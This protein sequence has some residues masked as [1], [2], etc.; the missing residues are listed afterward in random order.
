M[1][2]KRRSNVINHIN[3]SQNNHMLELYFMKNCFDETSNQQTGKR[4]ELIYDIAYPFDP[5]EFENEFYRDMFLLNEI[6]YLKQ[7]SK[8]LSASEHTFEELLENSDSN[9]QEKINLETKSIEQRNTRYG[10]KTELISIDDLIEFKSIQ[11][12]N[13]E[14]NDLIKILISYGYKFT[15]NYKYLVQDSNYE[16]HY[17][18]FENNSNTSGSFKDSSSGNFDQKLDSDSENKILNTEKNENFF[19]EQYW[20]VDLK[21]TPQLPKLTL[22]MEN[23]FEDA[24][25]NETCLS[26]FNS[27]YISSDSVSNLFAF[28]N[29]NREKFVNERNECLIISS[30]PGYNYNSID[31]INFGLNIR[32]KYR[33]KRKELRKQKTFEFYQFED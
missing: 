14:K 8:S 12:L 32:P 4:Y 33:K 31:A 19:E 6:K 15:S 7:F 24:S 25:D 5:Y 20:D 26:S 1:R 10:C 28:S 18:D 17:F 23:Q 3:R 13:I 11:K 29:L 30:F 2:E 22:T 9:K 21:A 27:N 16:N